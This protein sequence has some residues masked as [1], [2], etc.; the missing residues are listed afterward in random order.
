MTFFRHV[1][2]TSDVA[3]LVPKGRLMTEAEWREFFMFALLFF[4]FRIQVSL[5]ASL[6]FCQTFL[7]AKRFEH[8]CLSRFY[9][10]VW[11][12]VSYRFVTALL[13]SSGLFP[14]FFPGGL[15]VQQSRGWDHYA[16][17]K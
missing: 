1:I 14:T 8:I 3:K 5:V 17:H 2:L 4:H 11:N 16:I 7:I 10:A 9:A 6:P 13:I 15:G 12:T